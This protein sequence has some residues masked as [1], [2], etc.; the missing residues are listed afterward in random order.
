MYKRFNVVSCNVESH[1]QTSLKIYNFIMINKTVERFH[2]EVHNVKSGLHICTL[3]CVC[4]KA[5]FFTATNLKQVSE[6]VDVASLNLFFQVL[7]T[8]RV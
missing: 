4:R 2:V 1:T 7:Q 3:L 8:G 5:V 6:E